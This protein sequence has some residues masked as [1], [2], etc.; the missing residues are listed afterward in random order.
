MSITSTREPVDLVSSTCT[1]HL[2]C[3]LFLHGAL[4]TATCI[5]MACGV[6]MCNLGCC[7][8]LQC[9][10]ER[11]CRFPL[12]LCPSAGRSLRSTQVSYNAALDA[13]SKGGRSDK[14]LEL[15][16]EMEANGIEPEVISFNAAIDACARVRELAQ[17]RGGLL[18]IL[19]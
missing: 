5:Y 1:D 3:S 12:A 17:K 14:A 11:A 9:P 15:L 13:C 6:M 18:S 8:V 16:R 10:I 19:C 2:A 7:T 4:V